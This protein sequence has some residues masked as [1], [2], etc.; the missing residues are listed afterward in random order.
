MQYIFGVGNQLF[1]L[2]I[3]ILR[4]GELYQFNLIKLVLTDQTAGV[5]AGR[6]GLGTE[7]CGISTIFYRQLC[8]V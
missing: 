6:T 1:Q 3:R 5:S 7:A 2:C 8:T 4:T